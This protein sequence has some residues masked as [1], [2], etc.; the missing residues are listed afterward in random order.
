MLASVLVALLALT[1]CGDSSPTGP[2]AV[3][4]V[5]VSAPGDSLFP[6][7]AV[8][9]AVEIL[10]AAE[11]PLVDRP[12]S[13][14]SSDPG[15]ASV[16]DTGRLTA[17][18]PGTATIRAEAEGKTG[19]LA[20]TVVPVTIHLVVVGPDTG[21]VEV[22][23]AKEL[24]VTVFDSRGSIVIA[25]VV[26]WS[27]SD[28]SIATVSQWGVVTGVA[29]GTVTITATSGLVA[30]AARVTVL[31]RPHQGLRVFAARRGIG[32]GAATGS[33]LFLQQSSRGDTLRSVLAREFDMMWSGNFMKF[34][35]LRPTR[36]TFRYDR[37]DTMV[38][39]GD[40]HGI[41]ARGHTLVWHNQN[42]A[43]LTGGNWTREQ[44]IELM[45]EHIDGVVGHF[46]GRLA[47]WDVV[48]EA[49]EGNG[50]L[51]N[52]FWLQR[53]GPDYI[54]LAFRRAHQ[55]DPEVPLYY[56]DYNIEWVGSK[57][58]GV[59]NLVRDLLERGVPVH[60]VG[61]QGHFTSGQVPSKEALKTN[62][63]RFAAL[64]LDIQITELDI[65][66]RMP[67]TAADYQRQAQEYE[68]VVLACVETPRCNAVLIAGIWDGES[69][70]PGTFPG[71]DDALLFD[72]DFQPKPAYFGVRRALDGN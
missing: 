1:A 40:R 52:T 26:S 66:M 24:V 18:A 59:L 46:R 17:V 14:T 34:E 39:F 64:G 62:L 15:V 38:E 19:T 54:E 37:A 70:V 33:G 61:F 36:S 71:F 11:R 51:R 13:W 12:V 7:D 9:L 69:W 27:S 5:R 48:N 67:A 57:S 6:G 28:E 60:G 41:R 32:I 35:T 42:P 4:S 29:P 10:D 53:I 65:R 58:T 16:D 8:Q 20:V 72:R 49:V 56:N 68:R 3:A 50:D 30:G 25:P 2:P 21:S 63:A 47:A 45:Y 43:W 55:V 23:N 31:P 44:A 22:G